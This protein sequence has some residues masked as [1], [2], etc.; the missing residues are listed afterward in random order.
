MPVRRNPYLPPNVLTE[1]HDILIFLIKYIAHQSERRDN[2]AWSTETKP[3]V[4]INYV[5]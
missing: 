1:T 5:S 4:L 2:T 3:N